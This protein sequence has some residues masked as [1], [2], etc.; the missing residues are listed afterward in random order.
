[1]DLGLGIGHADPAGPPGPF[2]GLGFNLE[3]KGGLT[4]NLQ[5]GFRTGI[6]VGDDGKLTQADS[7]GRTFETETY[8]VLYDT[9]AN[10]ELSLRFTVVDSPLVDLALDGRLYIPIES[11][12][13]TGI[14]VAVPLA[15]HLSPTVRFD[16]GVYVPILF[17]DPTRTVISFPFH[18]WLQ[19]DNQWALGLL[20]GV[21]IS[22][23]GGSTGV[24]L[25]VALNYG[26]S[27]VADLRFWFLFP[28]VKNSGST[29]NFGAG[30]GLEIRF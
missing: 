24:P 17:Y 7:Y 9:V 16:T 29:K 2:T 12:A 1:V 14:M 18:L 25:G 28:D 19:L 6:R 23:P 5:L 20:T 30:I 22:N 15:F 10:P 3:I 21:R 8:G 26:A 11:G 13:K 4:S 27:S